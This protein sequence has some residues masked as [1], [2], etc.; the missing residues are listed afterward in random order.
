MAETGERRSRRTANPSG[1]HL[2]GSELGPP[3]PP[4]LDDLGVTTDESHR[5]QA[6]ASVPPEERQA[7]VAEAQQREQEVTRAGLLRFARPSVAD[8]LGGLRPPEPARGRIARAHL[9]EHLQLARIDADGV[10]AAQD[11]HL[12]QDDR[13]QIAAHLDYIRWRLLAGTSPLREVR[14]GA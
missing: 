13:E 1:T 8:P 4:T 6:V 14:H 5:W 12:S 7:Y 2:A 11:H 10:A 9:M 3:L